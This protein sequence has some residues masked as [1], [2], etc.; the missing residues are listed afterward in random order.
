MPFQPG[1]FPVQPLALPTIKMSIG[2]R[3]RFL[4]AHP[5][6]FATQAMCFFSGQGT[7][8]NAVLN[9]PLRHINPFLYAGR[10]RPRCQAHQGYRQ[11]RHELFSIHRKTPSIVNSH[12]ILTSAAIL[13]TKFDRDLISINPIHHFCYRVTTLHFPGDLNKDVLDRGTEH[14]GGRD[15]EPD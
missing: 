9:A 3:T 13:T 14:T 11:N 12:N 4:V 6:E 5:I 1:Q 7:G 10:Q 8:S 15:T 2:A